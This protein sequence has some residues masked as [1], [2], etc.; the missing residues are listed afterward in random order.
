MVKCP[1]Q[2]FLNI[3][4]PVSGGDA[5]KKNKQNEEIRKEVS[6]KKV[7]IQKCKFE[8]YGFVKRL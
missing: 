1:L 2:K 6:L 4:L 7:L 3:A 8:V 5:Y